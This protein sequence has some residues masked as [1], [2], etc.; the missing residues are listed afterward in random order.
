[1]L[2][3]SAPDG[4]L[5]GLTP[6]RMH[7]I[8]LVSD[9]AGFHPRVA[10]VHSNFEELGRVAQR[11]GFAG[12]DAVL[13]DRASRRCSSIGHRVLFLHKPRVRGHRFNPKQG[14]DA[15]ELVNRASQ[16]ELETLLREFGRG[17]TRPRIARAI[18]ARRRER[19]LRT[20]SDLAALIHRTV[21]PRS[22]KDRLRDAD[23]SGV[24]HGR[25]PRAEQLRAV[26]PQAVD[27]LGPGGRLAV[28]SF[29]SLED[30]VVKAFIREQAQGCV[31]PPESPVC[32]CGRRPTLRPINAEA[33]PPP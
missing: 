21:G 7:S 32:V 24:A 9:L 29:H 6:I 16:R 12:V 30:R 1:M 2:E 31:C 10:L 4:R 14:M 26:L 27:L 19:A 5:L 20:T 18:V 33:G 17:A 23:F 15:A 28:I 22:G 25:E 11:E 13:L 3:R 8:S